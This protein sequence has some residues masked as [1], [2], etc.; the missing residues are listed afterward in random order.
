MFSKSLT[1]SAACGDETGTT[2][3]TIL[4]VE[5]AGKLA[6]G[7]RRAAHDLG[8]VGEPVRAVARVDALGR[9]GEEKLLPDGEP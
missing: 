6:A 8:D 3:S 1:I 7:G 2:R 5:R 4:A 9:E